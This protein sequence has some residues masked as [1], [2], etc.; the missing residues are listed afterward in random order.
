M[1]RPISKPRTREAIKIDRPQKF[2]EARAMFWI[3][4]KV[5]IDHIQ[6]GFK[7]SVQYGR[8]LGR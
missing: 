7:H 8:H 4:R 6:S 3:F 1:I 2:E 5:L